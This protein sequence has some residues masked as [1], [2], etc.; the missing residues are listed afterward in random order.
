MI[1]SISPGY[2]DGKLLA[3][4]KLQQATEKAQEEGIFFALE[5]PNIKDVVATLVFD[6]SNSG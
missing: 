4:Q 6:A 2:A 3:V 5:M 1:M